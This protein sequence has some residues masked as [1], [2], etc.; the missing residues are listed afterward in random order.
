VSLF[1]E[2]LDDDSEVYILTHFLHEILV[3]ESQK[4][5]KNNSFF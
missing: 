5:F 1:F 2:E 4:L 3:A